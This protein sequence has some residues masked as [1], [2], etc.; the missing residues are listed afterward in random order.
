MVSR[1]CKLKYIIL[2]IFLFLIISPNS[3]FALQKKATLAKCVDGDTARFIING[4][5]YTARFLAIDTPETKH[6]KKKVEPFGKEASN[7]TCSRLKE[8]KKIVLEY[9]D[10]STKEDKY[11]RQLV[12]I[13]VDDSLLQDELIKKGYAKVAYLYDDYKYTKQLQREEAKAK[14]KKIGIWSDQ[15]DSIDKQTLSLEKIIDK[16]FEY[17]RKEIKSML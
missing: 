17:I 13:F 1:M 9:D 14:T 11:G 10:N 2:I 8:A 5:E 12:W 15:Q 3:V 4:N 6:P 7:Y 16:I